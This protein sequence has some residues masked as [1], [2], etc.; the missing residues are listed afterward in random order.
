MALCSVQ[1]ETHILSYSLA[2]E[3]HPVE[4]LCEIVD[5]GLIGGSI[6]TGMPKGSQ[7]VNK[8]PDLRVINAATFECRSERRIR[9]W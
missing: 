3:L 4:K 9:N 6:D 2:D 5:G 1:C 8:A 7:A